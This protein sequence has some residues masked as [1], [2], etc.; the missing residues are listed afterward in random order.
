[1]APSLITE[2]TKREVALS[3]GKKRFLQDFDL[4]KGQDGFE[5]E[6]SNL[7]EAQESKREISKVL[8]RIHKRF[9]L[10]KEWDYALESYAFYGGFGEEADPHGP[11]IKFALKDN[12]ADIRIWRETTLD[13]LKKAYAFVLKEWKQGKKTRIISAWEQKRDLAV[14]KLWKEGKSYKT[15]SRIIAKEYKAEPLDVG[16]LSSI[17]EKIKKRTKKVR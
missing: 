12:Y 6:I 1:M 11:Y 17:V 5:A 7:R 2:R 14:Y 8:N 10:G 13:D 3:R 15:I 9:Q 16:A 4:I